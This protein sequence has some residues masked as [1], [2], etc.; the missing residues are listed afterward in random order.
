MK[1][2]A[3]RGTLKERILAELRRDK[4]KT[5]LMGFLAVVALFLAAKTLLSQSAPQKVRAASTLLVQPQP[6]SPAGMQATA[7][8]KVKTQRPARKPRQ[9]DPLLTGELSS[10]IKRD[11]FLLNPTYFP[12]EKVSKPTTTQPAPAQQAPTRDKIVQAQACGLLLES[13][14]MSG[15]PVAI[16]NGQMR[17][18]GQSIGDF[19]IVEIAATSCIVCKDGVQ[20]QLNMRDQAPKVVGVEAESWLLDSLSAPQGWDQD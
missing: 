9:K 12:P 4:K 15:R 6:V 16:I 5:A 10:V 13:V 3:T 11:I 17:Q 8:Q 20:V 14:I 1:P 19:D 7:A 18:V 2:N